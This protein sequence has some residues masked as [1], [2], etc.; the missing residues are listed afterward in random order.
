MGWKGSNPRS[1]PYEKADNACNHQSGSYPSAC[2]KCYTHLRIDG[3]GRMSCPDPECLGGLSI[4]P[5]LIPIPPLVKPD[6]PVA[7]SSKMAKSQLPLILRTHCRNCRQSNSPCSGL[8]SGPRCER[9]EYLDLDC[10]CKVL[11]GSC[12][13]CMKDRGKVTWK[14]CVGFRDECDSCVER[15]LS[16]SSLFASQRR[17]APERSGLKMLWQMGRW[18]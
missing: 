8:I 17:Q 4:Y 16:A 1:K 6:V 13:E 5:Q 9:C 3:V 11:R 18:M 2:L 15:E 14:R 7:Q 12:E 10:D